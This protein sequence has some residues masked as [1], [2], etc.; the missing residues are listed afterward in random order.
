ML[1]AI[2]VLSCGGPIDDR[3]LVIDP[4]GVDLQ[5][6]R[7]GECPILDSHG[8]RELGLV[9]DAW[10]EDPQSMLPI[11]PLMGRLCFY[12]TKAG[13]E[14]HGM[15]ERQEVCGV[16]IGIQIASVAISEMDGTPLDI[17]EALERGYDDPDLLIIACRSLLTEVSITSMPGDPN[18]VVRAVGEDVLVR[19]MIKDGEA[20]LRR[21]LNRETEQDW[22]DL[23]P[24]KKFERVLWDRRL[25]HYGAP[26]PII[27]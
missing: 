19:Q 27:R 26:E 5:L 9:V 13:R 24:Q 15:I 1:E 23:D 20:K 7:D 25:V 22:R 4:R 6:V 16:S 10:V 11:S 8:H 17:E 14:A 21:I 3:G 2:A 12:D 18:A